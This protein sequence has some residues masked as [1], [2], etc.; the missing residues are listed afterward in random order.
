M[1]HTLQYV[2]QPRPDRFAGTA[3]YLV[4]RTG[5]LGVVVVSAGF[6]A[7]GLPS[8]FPLFFL[9]AILCAIICYM[10]RD[11]S[12]CFAQSCA[13]RR[14]QV[15]CYVMRLEFLASG[16]LYSMMPLSTAQLTLKYAAIGTSS[17][18]NPYFAMA[19][20]H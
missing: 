1:P 5:P 13:A 2:H 6:S 12:G 7:C 15:L 4:A 17:W 10:C 9:W 18:P 20:S 8:N 14:F 19:V 16:S 11:S 3:L